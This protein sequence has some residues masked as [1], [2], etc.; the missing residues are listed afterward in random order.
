M[1]LD[2]LRRRKFI[3]LLGGA[4]AWPLAARAQ[5]PALPVIGFLNGSTAKG[6]EPNVGAF[7]RG[8]G[9]RLHRRFSIPR[10]TLAG[11]EKDETLMDIALGATDSARVMS[12]ETTT[13]R[14]SAAVSGILAPE[15]VSDLR[16]VTKL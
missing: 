3:T 6:Y 7:H 5:Q 13:R 8:E 11:R 4:A 14:Y 12:R 2:Q 1:Q 15:R 9:H 16:I 10:G